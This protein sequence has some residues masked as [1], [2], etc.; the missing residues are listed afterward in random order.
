MRGS[1]VEPITCTMWSYQW[2]MDSLGWDNG[3]MDY[4]SSSLPRCK[5]ATSQLLLNVGQPVIET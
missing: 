5:Q 3:L 1:F 4:D 2:H